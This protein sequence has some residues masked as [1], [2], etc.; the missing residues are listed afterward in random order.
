MRVAT[1]DHPV[2]L[3]EPSD[4]TREAREKAVQLMFEKYKVPGEAGA[5]KGELLGLRLR[6]LPCSP[7]CRQTCEG[8]AAGPKGGRRAPSF[9]PTL[10]HSSPPAPSPAPPA[11]F[12]TR[13][14]VLS[15]FSTGRQTALVVDAGHESTVGEREGPW[16]RRG[17]GRGRAGLR[18]QVD[19][20][21]FVLSP[22]LLVSRC[23]CF[24]VSLLRAW[25]S[26]FTVGFSVFLGGQGVLGAL[27]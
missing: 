12:M 9:G 23:S 3:A 13:N 6:R 10:S 20:F 15:T 25:V 24:R 21:L 7:R 5:G 14:A 26:F 16:G 8:V 27:R 2:M 18:G 22:S 11:L 1:E 4:N 19:L 17:W